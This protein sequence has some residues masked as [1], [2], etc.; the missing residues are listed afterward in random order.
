MDMNKKENQ[1]SAVSSEVHSGVSG[2]Y[3]VEIIQASLE[4]AKNGSVFIT[5]A[6][7]M[8]NGKTYRQDPKQIAKDDGADG[9]YAGRLRA[10]FG[11]TNARDLVG[12]TTVKSGDFVDGEWKEK[13]IEVLSYVDLIGKKLGAVLFF[14]QKYP[15]SLGIN[16]YTGRPIPRRDEDE[17]AYEE[18]KR[19]ATTIWM[20]NY[21]KQAQ[22]VFDFTTFFDLA[23]EKTYSELRDDNLDK[24]T[25]V[26]KALEEVEKK[27][28]KP[29]TLLTEDWDKLRVKKLKANLKKINEKYD[30]KAFI[31][32]P[33]SGV[34]PND[35]SDDELV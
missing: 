3:K 2:K 35:S 24:G 9:Y 10:I 31:P 16:G 27:S 7:K 26:S 23:T 6:F 34:N 32:S 21:E 17:K 12:T 8:P 20:P 15:E 25:K 5:L 14:Y 11:L 28:S 1:E 33:G 30:P 13:D 19:L 18:A 29:V 22:P 4:E